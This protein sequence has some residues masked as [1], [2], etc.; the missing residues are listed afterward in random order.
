MRVWKKFPRRSI[1]EV[2]T[3]ITLSTSIGI[4]GIKSNRERC[5]LFAVSP[6]FTILLEHLLEKTF[7]YSWYNDRYISDS[8]PVIIGGCARSGT[9]LIRVML[10]SHKN[11]YCGPETGLLYTKTINDNKIRNISRQLD[12]PYDV[13]VRMKKESKSNIQFIENIFKKL[14]QDTQKTRW[15]EKSP[16]NVLH[17]NRIF[18]YFP[19]AR[20]VH[21]IRDG[22]DTACSLKH[23][24]N[25]RVVEGEV[26][27]LDTNNPLN[28]CIQRWVHD[29]RKGIEWR[30][31]PRYMEVK[32]EDLVSEPEK[33]I[34]EVLDFLNEPWD[35]NVLNYHQIQSSS[36]SKEKIPQNISAQKPI[37]KSAYG[38]WKNEF[39]EEDKTLFKNLAGDLLIEL[40]YEKDNDW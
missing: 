13:L 38:R 25:T 23:F 4:L 27:K 14:Q 31:D 28:E 2:D 11:I 3:D 24:P 17:I 8:N 22:R 1:S 7:N 16:M 26:I 15:G 5:N 34:R 12:I 39:T 35:E 40:G 10:D 19:N 32:Y 6:S 20:F 33:T 29:V 9:T 18:K 30:R 37:Y 21:M 36:R